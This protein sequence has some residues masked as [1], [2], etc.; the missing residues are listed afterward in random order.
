[1]ILLGVNSN[2]GKPTKKSVQEKINN[3]KGK[4]DTNNKNCKTGKGILPENDLCAL[5]RII[6]SVST[7]EHRL[8]SE[9]LKTVSR[10]LDSVKEYANDSDLASAT[11]EA[12][13]NALNNSK[14]PDLRHLDKKVTQVEKISLR[15]L[16]AQTNL[17][18]TDVKSAL[19]SA[20]P[21]QQR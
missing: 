6:S 17:K 12:L 11:L 9:A 2:M 13:E 21:S 3:L 4:L 8:S 15:L 16:P 1:M 18:D 19:E 7:S 10:S 14:S 20:G 5:L